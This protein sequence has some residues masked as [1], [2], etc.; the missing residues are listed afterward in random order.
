MSQCNP[1]SCELRPVC[2]RTACLMRCERFVFERKWS[3]WH[4]LGHSSFL[5]FQNFL[6]AY[7]S[8]FSFSFKSTKQSLSLQHRHW[9]SIYPLFLLLILPT[10][11]ILPCFLL[12][13]LSHFSSSPLTFY[14]Q[15]GSCQGTLLLSTPTAMQNLFFYISHRNWCFLVNIWYACN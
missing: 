2:V 11:L 5:S 13:I 4:F 7:F 8:I 15:K 3:C 12:L 1:Q 6:L 10:F 9:L 14:R